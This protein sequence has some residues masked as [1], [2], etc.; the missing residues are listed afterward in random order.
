MSCFGLTESKTLLASMTAVLSPVSRRQA[1]RTLDV[2]MLTLLNVWLS[3]LSYGFHLFVVAWSL[4]LQLTTLHG[5]GSGSP[6]AGFGN[7]HPD[8]AGFLAP[9]TS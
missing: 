8:L 2:A 6:L 5:R 3:R 7:L 4:S 1:D 9:T